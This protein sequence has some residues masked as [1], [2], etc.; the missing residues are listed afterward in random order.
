MTPLFHK[1]V[2]FSKK[3]FDKAGAWGRKS[4]ASI[5]LLTEVQRGFKKGVKS[6]RERETPPRP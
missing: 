2:T 1:K 3:R 6:F 5:V 4:V